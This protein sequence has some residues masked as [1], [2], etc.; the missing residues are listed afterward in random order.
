VRKAVKAAFDAMSTWQTEVTNSSQK[1]LERVIDKV[2][3]AAEALDGQT[4]LLTP[5]AR[6]CKLL[7]RCSHK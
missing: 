6:K 5:Y 7:P 2:A 1:N 3:A 4:K